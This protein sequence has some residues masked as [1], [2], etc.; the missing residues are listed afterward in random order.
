M[1]K[2]ILLALSL[3]V[4]L[5][6]TITA[7]AQ[8]II[9]RKNGKT[10]EAKIIEVSEAEVK[11]KLFTQPDGV[12]FVMDAGLIKK[13]VLANGAVHKFEEGGSIDNK[14]YYE[15]QKKNAYKVN[16]LGIIF[17][18]TT[19]GYERSLKP[20][21][22]FD[23]RLT[24]IGLGSTSTASYSSS[25]SSF[26]PKLLG[27]GLTGGYKFINKP[28]YY[29]SR[30]RYSHILKGSYIRPEITLATYSEDRQTY[31]YT[32]PNNYQPTI[33]R[34]N[35]TYG[36]LMLTFGKQWVFENAF[37]VDVYSGIGVGAQT[38][39]NTNSYNEFGVSGRNYGGHAIAPNGLAFNIG[40]NIGILGK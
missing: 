32:P 38:I 11:Y 34:I 8:D 31:S 1:K 18:Y 26:N 2:T 4:V 9:H 23:A 16:F 5:F 3:F 10:I 35:T 33:K 39:K 24:F 30:Q 19:L 28:D 12:T 29:S 13:I 40:L 36:C 22:S 20:G 14:E 6:S 25:N 27:I 21:A 37:L 15:G 7:T 17:G